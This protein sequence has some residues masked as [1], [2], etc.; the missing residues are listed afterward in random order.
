LKKVTVFGGTTVPP[1][2]LP[3]GACAY[4]GEDQKQRALSFT[5]EFNKV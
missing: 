1:P 2:S 5:H 3:G 4:A